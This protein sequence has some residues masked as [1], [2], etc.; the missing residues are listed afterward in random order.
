MPSIEETLATAIIE[1]GVSYSDFLLL[2]LDEWRAIA[3]AITTHQERSYRN[4]WEQTRLIAWHAIAPYLKED[5][6]I[7]QMLP[8]PWDPPQNHN[9]TD[10]AHERPSDEEIERMMRRF[11][12][13]PLTSNI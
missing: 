8:L 7:Y 10:R 4:Q 5:V 12:N 11:G 1:G 6:S 9:H 3:E 13:S 2:T